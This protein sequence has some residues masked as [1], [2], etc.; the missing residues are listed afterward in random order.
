MVKDFIQYTEALELKQ[1]GFD[2]PCFAFYDE[3]L[4]FPNNENQYGTFCN[5]KLDAS[6]CSAPTYSQ[7]F[8]W[9]RDNGK[10]AEIFSQLLPSNKYKWGFKIQGVEGVTDGFF[11]YEEAE[12]ACLREMIKIVKENHNQIVDEAYKNYINKR[13]KDCNKDNYKESINGGKVIRPFTKGEFIDKC[14]THNEFSEYWGLKIEERE[15]SLPKLLD[16]FGE[17]GWEIMK[18]ERLKQTGALSSV[19]EAEYKW[20][21]FMKRKN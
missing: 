8:R 5:Q 3:S 13:C 10:V 21:L 9:F 18:V 12:L 7:A 16:E 6:S 1:L 20:E 2:E 17:S 15:L 14:K 4:Y 19:G 11:T